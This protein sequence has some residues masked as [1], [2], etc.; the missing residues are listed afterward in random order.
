MV[1][2]VLQVLFLEYQE[3]TEVVEEE[4]Q[5]L[6]VLRVQGEPVAVAT[7]M[8]VLPVQTE[9]QTREVEEEEVVEQLLAQ[10]EV[11]VL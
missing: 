9:K 5:E 11:L 1:V 7:V 2:M 3:H 6:V 10:T 4:A 8:L